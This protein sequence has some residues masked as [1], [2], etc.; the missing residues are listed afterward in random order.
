MANNVQVTTENPAVSA[1]AEVAPLKLASPAV[2]SVVPAS[3]QLAP[4][5]CAVSRPATAQD[6]ASYYLQVTNCQHVGNSHARVLMAKALTQALIGSTFQK[7]RLFQMQGRQRYMTRAE[8]DAFNHMHFARLQSAHGK[9]GVTPK[10]HL[11]STWL[12]QPRWLCT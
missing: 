10:V 1:A 4:R 8:C 2:R 3:A 6:H 12:L 11:F 9:R 5:P 7:D